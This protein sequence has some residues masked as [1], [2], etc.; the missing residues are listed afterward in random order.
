MARWWVTFE[1]APSDQAPLQDA[2]TMAARGSV[3]TTE[4]EGQTE[5]VAVMFEIEKDSSE[6]ALNDARILYRMVRTAAGLD[7]D[8]TPKVSLFEADHPRDEQAFHQDWYLRARDHLSAGRAD[9][10]VLF[11]QIACET[12]IRG[13]F[14]HLVGRAVPN[15]MRQAVIDSMRNW[16]LSQPRSRK[17]W[18]AVAQDQ[19]G[20]ASWWSRYNDHLE[21][22]NG[23]VHNGFYVTTTE[24]EQ[25]LAAV[26]AFLGHIAGALA[27]NH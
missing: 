9:E 4:A 20:N 10:A 11:A 27:R 26:D 8:P 3:I 18:D 23:L 16:N 14:P 7:S 21:R 12:L 6:E 2:S 19:I 24:A 5:S 25:S 13:V 1:A 17:L 15:S 22:R